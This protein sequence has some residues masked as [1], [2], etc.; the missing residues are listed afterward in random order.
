MTS[1]NDFTVNRKTDN[2]RYPYAKTDL[3][4]KNSRNQCHIPKLQ[5][6]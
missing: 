3:L 6:K 4:M 2:L 5:V 1:I